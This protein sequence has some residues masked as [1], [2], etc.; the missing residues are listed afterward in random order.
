MLLAARRLSEALQA[1]LQV[2]SPVAQMLD[3]VRS[4]LPSSSPTETDEAERRRRREALMGLVGLAS[5]EPQAAD[6]VL[7]E[8][9][10]LVA[11]L[12]RERDP[13]ERLLAFRLLAACCVH[14]SFVKRAFGQE[15]PTAGTAAGLVRVL[16]QQ[17]QEEEDGDKEEGGA[18]QGA[19]ADELVLVRVTIFLR[20]L[21]A[22]GA[23]AAEAGSTAAA[24]T[25]EALDCW[26]RAL[27]HDKVWV[28]FL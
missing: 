20:A 12:E 11:L 13:D 5:Q 7:R 25:E 26:T 23:A 27:Q 19:E 10:V 3:A 9:E 8:A 14:P 22:L 2:R 18:G 16:E 28:K 6:D 15:A 21:M 17:G 1:Q 24:L 4:P